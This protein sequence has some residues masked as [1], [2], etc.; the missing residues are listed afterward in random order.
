MASKLNNQSE[1]S[2][3]WSGW[4]SFFPKSHFIKETELWLWSCQVG[5]H[6]SMKQHI[7]GAHASNYASNI[8]G[9]K[10]RA[11]Q[12]TNFNLFAHNTRIKSHNTQ[13]Q[14]NYTAHGYKQLPSSLNWLSHQMPQDGGALICGTPP[15]WHKKFKGT[16]WKWKSLTHRKIC[17]VD[18]PCLVCAWNALCVWI[19]SYFIK[20]SWYAR[21][22]VL[23]IA[24]I[25]ALILVHI[26]TCF[27]LCVCAAA[28]PRVNRREIHQ[29]HSYYTIEGVWGNFIICRIVHQIHQH[30]L[31]RSTLWT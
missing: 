31:A 14:D 23:N 6:F 1:N 3:G 2:L 22:D 29:L 20:L 17:M 28:K 13:S 12:H 5:R 24:C 21:A 9:Y 26:F 10:Y 7:D 25:V 16:P 15:H 8:S 27:T 11:N 30:K 4:C 19:H 18:V